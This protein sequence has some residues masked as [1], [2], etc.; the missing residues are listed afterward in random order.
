[1]SQQPLPGASTVLAM[2][3]VSLVSS[4]ICCG[5]LGTIFALIALN[6]AKEAQKLYQQNPE[7]YTDYS[8]VTAG[9][10]LAYVGLTLSLIFLLLLIL[11]CI[12]YFGV[13]VA[14]F[15]SIDWENEMLIGYFANK[16]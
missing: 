16:F 11:Y 6:K 4:L 14:M 15:S 2:G 1:M 12:I 3:I 13:I 9:R 5:L 10:T 7:G 8:N